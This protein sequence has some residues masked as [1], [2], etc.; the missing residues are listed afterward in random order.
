MFEKVFF[1]I[2]HLQIV[3]DFT[4]YTI[5]FYKSLSIKNSILIFYAKNI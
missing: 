3:I 5:L 4:L 2:N 1:H